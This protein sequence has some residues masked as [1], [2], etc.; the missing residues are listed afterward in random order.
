MT[1][2]RIAVG[3]TAAVAGA[4]HRNTAV[5]LDAAREAHRLGADI[6]VL[7]EMTVAGY[8]VDDLLGD[9]SFL[10]ACTWVAGGLVTDLPAGLVTVFGAP[11]RPAALPVAGGART[12]ETDR[13][14]SYVRTVRNAAVVAVGGRAVFAR[15]K[16]AL[17]DYSTFTDA[18][19]FAR[20]PL[21]T[22]TVLINGVRCAVLV[23]EDLW[24]ARIP[25]A[26]AAAGATVLL[27]PN[28]SPYAYGKPALRQALVTETARR[29]GCTVVWVGFAC[30]Q[31]EA[32]YD[33]GSMVA[34]PDGTLALR[35]PLFIEG[36][37]AVDVDVPNAGTTRP[38]EVR[39]ESARAL[40]APDTL[41]AV[42]AG[43]ETGPAELWNALVVGIRDYIDG[44]GLRGVI[45]GMSGG[46][47]SGL[48]AALA[49]DALGP[50]RVWGI[51]MP[52]PY[53]SA[54]SVDDA[55]QSAAN[56]GIRFDI[57]PIKANYDTEVDV[58][59]PLLDAGAPEGRTVGTPGRGVKVA[60][61][62]VQA[63]NRALHL[64]T[65]AN[66]HGMLV[67]GTS[68]KSESAVGYFTLFGDAA[69]GYAPIKDVLKTRAYDLCRWRNQVAEAAGQ[70]PRV[71]WATVDKVPSAEL[72][73]DQADSDSL[74]PYPV[75]DEVLERY[76]TL[77]QDPREIADALTVSGRHGPA[78]PQTEADA[79]VIRVL[80]MVDAAEHKRRQCPPGIRISHT[81]S[82]GRDRKVPITNFYR[83][84]IRR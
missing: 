36:V 48:T 70:T 84:V 83:H 25:D 9:P 26:A 47:D 19:W 16:H 38:G 27:V 33:G 52:G 43:W 63:R 34:R 30:G 67:L 66:T 1:V 23:C 76:L 44:T 79:L 72:A 2:L 7:P 17:P 46:L 21:S 12:D 60:L 18:R 10:D 53:S 42:L 71:P 37:W 54:G 8:P 58:L 29:T 81:G 59:C 39:V 22:E 28:A 4:V 40:S 55:A 78:M 31:D 82:F 57:L 80:R 45:I 61:E 15:A 73:L 51:G 20:G 5:A 11:L 64:M 74:P 14:D 32:V 62:N 41:D 65:L 6:L 24:D 13:L 35:A 77:S 49:V 68:N 50:A 3:Q 69:A 56:L 75:L